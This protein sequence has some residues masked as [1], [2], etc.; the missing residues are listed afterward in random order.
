M[1]YLYENIINVK[2][3]ISCFFMQLRVIIQKVSLMQLKICCKW[4]YGIAELLPSGLVIYQVFED[5]SDIWMVFVLK[6]KDS[7]QIGY[8]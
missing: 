5:L 6:F 4:V 8:E 1:Y 2:L 7:K 3:V